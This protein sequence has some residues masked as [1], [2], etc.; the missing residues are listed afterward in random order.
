MAKMPSAAELHPRHVTVPAGDARL[1][2]KLTVP[3]DA[4]GVVVFAQGSGSGRFSSRSRYVAADLVRGGLATLLV[5]LLTEAEEARRPENHPSGVR[6]SPAR[7][8]GSGCTA[9]RSTSA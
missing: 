4:C 2:G 9:A 7:P 6:H 5:D 3:R 8:T 1:V